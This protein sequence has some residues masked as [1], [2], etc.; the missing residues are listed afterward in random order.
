MTPVPMAFIAF[1]LISSFATRVAGDLSGVSVGAGWFNPEAAASYRD[2]PFQPSTSMH[3]YL[4]HLRIP[5]ED[6]Y[7]VTE[8]GYILHMH[9]LPQV[10]NTFG[11]KT[12]KYLFYDV[13]INVRLATM[14]TP[15]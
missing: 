10:H 5:L 6:H 7:T 8:D 1:A 13:I 15:L 11:Q 4:G 12:N 2:F 3:Q 14:M 9:R